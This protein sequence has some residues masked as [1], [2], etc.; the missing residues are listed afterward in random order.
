M[1]N[2]TTLTKEE[3]LKLN[4][5]DMKEHALLQ[6]KQITKLTAEIEHMKNIMK[7]AEFIY[8]P[9]CGNCGEEGCCGEINEENC[10]TKPFCLWKEDSILHSE[11]FHDKKETE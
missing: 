1:G 4:Y 9:E 10:K 11:E 8:C 3:T 7:K 2:L 6:M 5:E